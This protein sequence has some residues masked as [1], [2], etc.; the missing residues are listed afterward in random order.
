MNGADL[1]MLN[2]YPVRLIVPG[3]YGTYWV[4]HL[5][6]STVIDTVFDGFW[7]KRPTASPTTTAP[8][9]SPAPRRRRRARS[10]ASTCARSSPVTDGAHA[11]RPAS[12][13]VRGIAFDGG[14]GITR[15]RVFGRRRQDAGRGAKLGADLG[16][17]SFREWQLPLSRRAPGDARAQGA[18]R[19]T[20]SARASRWSAVES[21]R[22]T[23]A[24]SSRR[25]ASPPY[26]RRHVKVFSSPG[27]H[28]R[29]SVAKRRPA[30]RRSLHFIRRRRAALDITMPMETAAYKASDL[31]G[32]R[33]VQQHCLACHS[34]QYVQTQPATSPRAYWDA[35]VKKMKKPFGAKF[36]DD[37]IPAI[38]DYLVKTYG[39]ERPAGAVA[40]TM[41]AAPP[42]AA[43]AST[44]T[45][46]SRRQRPHGGHRARPAGPPRCERLPCLS[47]RRQK[48]RRACIQG[49]RRE[50][51]RRCQRTGAHWR[52]HSRRRCRQMGPGADAAIP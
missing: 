46:S 43:K 2:G 24:T 1:P 28:S 15:G 33:L 7:M 42:S 38:V 4:K 49:S 39:N 23:C 20:A 45:S 19:A 10:A 47:C 6:T 11:C 34:A 9:S 48:N 35:T 17:Y 44:S 22:A 27:D 21:G 8:A 40:S 51:R 31:P 37:E 13:G 52:E 50:I 30:A 41:S 32:Y 16:S 25:R 26:R 12:V 36:S 14:H 18:R 29:G 3:Y 5:P